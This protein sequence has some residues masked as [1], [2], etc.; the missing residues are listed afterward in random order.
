METPQH[1]LKAVMSGYTGRGLNDES[2]LTTLTQTR[3]LATT[4]VA[5]Y[6]MA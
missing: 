3:F 5:A 6:R 1:T 4:G 2:V